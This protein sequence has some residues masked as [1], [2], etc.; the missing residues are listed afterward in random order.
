MIYNLTVSHFL[1]TQYV[2]FDSKFNIKAFQG[3]FKT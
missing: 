1:S 3:I 2:L